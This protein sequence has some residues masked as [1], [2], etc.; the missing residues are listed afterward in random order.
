MFYVIM[1]SI[2][3]NLFRVCPAFSEYVSTVSNVTGMEPTNFGARVILY[4][5]K[6]QLE[7]PRVIDFE[8]LKNIWE[9]LKQRGACKRLAEE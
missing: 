4:A 2:S 3:W 6:H 1:V 9:V 5:I 8:R 7:V